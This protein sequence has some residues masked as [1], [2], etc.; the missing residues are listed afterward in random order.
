[1]A[2]LKTYREKRDFTKT[3]EPSGKIQ[4]GGTS[5]IFVVQRH[6]A[7][8]LHY[9]LRLELDGV[10]KSWEI[11][12]GPSLHPADKRLAMMTEDHPY[13][14]KDFEGTIPEGEY[15]AGE[16]EIWDSGT[17]EPLEKPSRGKG[18]KQLRN[19]L[20]NG[21]MKI[22]LHGKKLKGEFALV[23]IKNASDNAWLLIK[24]KD[25]FA[26]SENYNA[27][28][29]TP[30]RSAVTRNLK[31]RAANKSKNG[32]ENNQQR[33]TTLKK[34]KSVGSTKTQTL[35][36]SKIVQELISSPDKVYWPD[37]GY[38]KADLLNYYDSVSKYIL[39][40]LKGRPQSLNRFPDGITG[41]SFYQ[42]DAPG[43]IPDWI[44]TVPVHAESTNEMIDYILVN[45]KRSLLY[46]ANLGCIEMNPW[47]SHLPQ[48]EYPDYLVMD[49]DPSDQNDFDD[50]IEV[51]LA[52]KDILDEFQIQGYPKTSG[53]TGMHI[54]IPMGGKYDYDLV[55]TFAQL[56]AQKTIELLPDLTTITRSLSKRDKNKI[57]VDYLQN[58]KGQTVASAYSVRPKPGATVSMPLTWE[59]VKPGL[60]P[61]EFTIENALARLEEKG[62]LFAPVL[63]KGVN[64]NKILK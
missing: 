50:V 53:S 45:E 21:S 63:R 23:K 48:L 15:G 17:Y 1:M 26:V 60:S 44:E 20:D 36:M 8:N 9:D 33:E 24:H 51:S 31:R 18:E 22:V 49:I 35:K 6:A 52:L 55:K 7:R 42:K 29:Y 13:A 2:S 43:H 19:Q 4:K 41:K 57:Y 58:R 10:L 14:Y 3:R 32:L 64:L 30:Q 37:E 40:Y 25:E 34:G 5:L 16:M 54:F 11:P 47:S 56:L 28:A 38:T 46:L 27:E 12:K 62:D 59:E 39:P 61:R